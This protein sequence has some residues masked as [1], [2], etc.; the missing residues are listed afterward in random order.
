MHT[1]IDRRAKAALRRPKQCTGSC[2]KT[3]IVR[4]HESC[5]QCIVVLVYIPGRFKLQLMIIRTMERK[6][7]SIIVEYSEHK[8]QRSKNMN[9]Y[10]SQDN[11]IKYK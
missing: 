4:A 9:S 8:H 3:K 11:S 10:A 6:L 1:K 2:Q 7:K 5:A